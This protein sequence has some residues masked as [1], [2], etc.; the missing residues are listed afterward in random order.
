MIAIVQLGTQFNIALVLRQ[1]RRFDEGLLYAQAALR[2]Y[3]EFG[4]GAADEVHNTQEL[5][6]AIEADMESVEKGG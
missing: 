6:A 1:G 5:I 4:P 3:Q 2:N